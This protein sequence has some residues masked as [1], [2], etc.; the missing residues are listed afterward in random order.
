MKTIQ[1]IRKRLKTVTQ[2]QNMFLDCTTNFYDNEDVLFK[3][4]KPYAY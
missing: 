2:K 1:N 4:I 3:K